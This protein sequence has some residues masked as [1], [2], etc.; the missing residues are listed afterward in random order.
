MN[1]SIRWAVAFTALALTVAAC[2]DDTAATTTVESTTTVAVTTTGATTTTASGATSTTSATTTTTSV[3]VTT[4]GAT[5][6]TTASGATSTTGATTSTSAG[7]TSTTA[8]GGE[9]EIDIS[10]FA[11]QPGS[12]TISKGTKVRWRNRDG[13]THTTTGGGWNASLAPDAR[14]SFTFDTAGSYPYMCTIHPSMT[15]T[16]TVSG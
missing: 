12:V 8:A 16:I 3:A 6:T 5:T 2:S 7:T 9:V 13:V 1:R 15:G 4:T 10:G 11:F 14:F